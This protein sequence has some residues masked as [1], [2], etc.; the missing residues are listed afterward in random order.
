M[1]EKDWGCDEFFLFSLFCL[2]SFLVHFPWLRAVLSRAIRPP[3]R[4]KKK[5]KRDKKGI[6]QSWTNSWDALGIERQR[7]KTKKTQIRKTSLLVGEEEF[8][9][10][11]LK[12]LTYRV[13]FFC[14]GFSSSLLW[15]FFV[16]AVFLQGGC[17]QRDFPTGGRHYQTTTPL[18][19]FFFL[20]LHQD[21]LDDLL[22][23]YFYQNVI[24]INID[25][26]N[27]LF[28]NDV[29]FVIFMGSLHNGLWPDR[30]WALRLD[31]QPTLSLQYG[32]VPVSVPG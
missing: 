26:A 8:G 1:E 32:H 18:W 23:R 15:L 11:W 4:R 22:W 28:L 19:F 12:A 31:G 14:T 5:T 3:C 20:Y 13:V 25:I 10:W 27:P 16:L 21:D 29:H 7:K 2:L 24:H 6:G 17:A 9:F 30:L